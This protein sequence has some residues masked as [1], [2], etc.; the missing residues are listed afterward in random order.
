[1]SFKV[2]NPSGSSAV[3]VQDAFVDF[4]VAPNEVVD[5]EDLYPGELWRLTFATMDPTLSPPYTPPTD[6]DGGALYTAISTGALIRV[7]NDGTTQI[8]WP[9]TAASVVMQDLTYTAGEAMECGNLFTIGYTSGGT[10]G[11]EVV[12]ISGYDVTVQ[13]QNGVSTANQVKAAIEAN[14]TTNALFV[15]TVTGVGTNP[16]YAGAIKASKVIQDLTYTADTAGVAGNAIS[17]TY[18]DPGAP[19]QSISVSVVGSDIDVSLATDGSGVI[20]SDADSIKA[21]IDGTPAAAALVDI[22]VSGTGTNVQTAQAQT[23][24]E[25]GYDATS[26][27]TGG[28]NDPFA[29]AI[30]LWHL[31]K[32][33]WEA[34]AGSYGCPSDINRFVT[35]ADP[36]SNPG[37]DTQ[38]VTST[39]TDGTIDNY[40][41]T[42]H[43]HQGIHSLKANGLG[44]ARYGD[45]VLAAGTDITI[46]DNG[47]GTFT[48]DVAASITTEFYVT[49]GTGLVADYNAGKATIDGAVYILPAGT[50]TVTDDATNYV[51]LDV[52]GV[53]KANTTGY[54]PNVTPLA[55]VVAA[56]GDVTS[57]TDNRSFVNQSL[58]WGSVGDITTIQPDDT[59]AVGTTDK[60]AMADHR[61]A[62]AADVPLFIGETGSG[63]TN[64]EGDST[65]F[66][67]AD[68]EHKWQL[69]SSFAGLPATPVDGQVV[70]AKYGVYNGM[71]YYDSTR[72]KWL[73]MN[74]YVKHWNSGTNV[75]T[76]TVNL[77]S[78]VDDTQQDNDYPNPYTITICG[79]LGCQSNVIATNNNTKFEVAKYDLTTGAITQDIANVTLSTVGARAVR[80]MAVNVDVEDLT[81][82]SARR[83][84]TGTGNAQVTRPALSVFYRVRLAA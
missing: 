15:V 52:D 64:A 1:M 20:T 41:R 14:P 84:K 24:L 77:I 9:G 2:L 37:A 4:T 17:L 43:T 80:S 51:Y 26:A 71:F 63:A 47:S 48:F 11:S 82:L 60:Y 34:L 61:H 83:V 69:V 45:L 29:D 79:L 38:P 40:A 44:T 27:F 75:A 8:P 74:E 42:D 3:V 21:A 54:P 19:N 57:V 78:N 30:W 18:T 49:E 58:V 66:A 33:Q 13:I 39:T 28:S 70:W 5:V 81:V 12:S 10:A 65:S 50:V 22:T 31:T 53:V 68:H 59:A 25:N 7:K 36:S 76:I 6:G 56:S 73:S 23:N 16:Q 35:E 46:T 62:I 55:V 32:Y 67:R 72:T